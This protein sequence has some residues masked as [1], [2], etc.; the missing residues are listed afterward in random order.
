MRASEK[1]RLGLHRLGVHF[2]I[3]GGIQAGGEQFL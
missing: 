3:K 1:L 2:L